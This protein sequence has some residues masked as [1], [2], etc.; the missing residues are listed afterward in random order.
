MM[1]NDDQISNMFDG[2]SQSFSVFDPTASLTPN[3]DD[4][5]VTNNGGAAAKATVNNN[6]GV[7]SSGTGEKP[8]ATD[9]SN[10]V[11]LKPN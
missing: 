3:N 1:M 10:L 4:N 11:T 5:I 8:T 7:A 9:I 6:G 2:E